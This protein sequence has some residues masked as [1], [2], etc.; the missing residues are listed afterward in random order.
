MN[1]VP[2]I[3][4]SIDLPAGL[5]KIYM[6]GAGGI[7]HDAHLPAYALAGFSVAGIYDPL[8]EKSTGAGRKIHDSQG[9]FLPG[10]TGERSRN[11]WGL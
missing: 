9:V 4:F 6:I 1:S 7:V 10:R 8:V 5:H 3:K 2:E 11:F